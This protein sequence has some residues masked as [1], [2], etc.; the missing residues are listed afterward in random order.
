MNN[1]VNCL[2]FAIDF[3]NYFEKMH[4]TTYK[5]TNLFDF[6]RFVIATI[7]L[8][9]VTP[10]A[11]EAQELEPKHKGG[12]FY[13]GIAG[14]FSQ[15]LAENAVKTDFITHQIP[16][17]NLLIGYNFTP[18]FGLRLTGGFNAQTSRC[19][20]AAFKAMPEVYG[21]GR[22]GFNT[23]TGT[24]SGVINLTNI[25]MGYDADR[26][27]T[28]SLL[29]GGGYLKSFNF[30]EEKLAGWNKYP[31]YPV[32]PQGGQYYSGH[33]GLQC[34]A[35]LSEP[36][37]LQFELRGNATDNRYNG[38]SNGNHLDFYLD[39]M[40]NFVYHFKNHSQHLRR[41]RAPKREPFLD[42]VLRDDN[43]NYRETVRYGEAMH[44]T[45][46]FYAGFY[47]INNASLKRIGIVANFL[48]NNP[49]VNV[50]VVGHPDVIDDEDLEYNHRL[51]QK[52]AEAVRETLIE[53]YHI[54]SSR[55]RLSYDDTILQPYKSVR[56][57]IPSVNFIM[58][59]ADNEES[60]ID[61][62]N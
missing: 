5:H 22:Y 30:D 25:F 13:V 26:P 57:W 55:I 19:S 27:A 43:L 21:N 11:A 9:F 32:D 31:Y 18:A 48:K 10:N 35:R 1:S 40:V 38:V 42:P 58:E 7:L 47:Y 60:G 17:A 3:L 62:I 24:L 36:F 34:A 39:L 15:S 59:E 44:T 52:R 20:N 37:D 2:K 51:A 33:L 56:E 45:I 16:S 61:E 49:L 41:F 29:M 50:A 4:K 6:V 46:P 14:G 28:F 23:L 54:E 12:D 8:A 53:R